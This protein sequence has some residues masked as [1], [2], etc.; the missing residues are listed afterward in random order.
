MREAIGEA[1]AAGK[2]VELVA[3]GSKCGLGRPLQVPRILDLSRLAGIRD[4][5]PAELVLTAAA[6]TPLAEV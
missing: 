3:G 5:Q 4:Y 2:P 1:L 6:A